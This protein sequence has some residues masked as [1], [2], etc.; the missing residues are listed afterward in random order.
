MLKLYLYIQFQAI[1]FTKGLVMSA[2]FSPILP[3]DLGFKQK[4]KLSQ[5]QAILMSYLA[6]LPNWA[7]DVNN[8]GYF[9]IL[10]AKIMEDLKM[11]IK[12][13]ENNL[14]VL[15]DLDLIKRARTKVAEWS[16]EKNFRTVKITIKGKEYGLA[17]SK[18]KNPN[19]IKEWEVKYEN[20]EKLNKK[21]VAEN[22]TLKSQSKK[23]D[24][25]DSLESFQKRVTKEFGKSCKPI[26]NFVEN[27]DNWAKDSQ[28]WIN[29]YGKLTI[30]TPNGDF[31]QI[32]NPEKIANFWQWLF[33]N[34]ERCGVIKTEQ[35]EKKDEVSIIPTIYH[36]LPFIGLMILVEGEKLLINKLE[37]VLG[38]VKIVLQNAKTWQ[39]SNPQIVDV[40]V[41]TNWIVKRREELQR[42]DLQTEM[43]KLRDLI[44]EII[45]FQNQKW[46]ISSFIALKEGK[47]QI[48]VKK[49]TILGKKPPQTLIDN[50]RKNDPIIAFT[51]NKARE[52]IDYNKIK[53]KN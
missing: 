37:A 35:T 22:K 34:P 31:K 12:T 23:T 50:Q 42:F 40:E 4:Y 27:A 10:T 32:I 1:I 43:T 51:P 38:G 44:G 45:L 25:T 36:L 14:K 24:T 2:I 8:D 53:N 15:E 21:L 48:M 39:L 16:N 28:F 18:C 19:L 9:L 52:F 49:I 13:V 47:I 6:L 46:E 33:K 11:G 26:C 5:S 29:S 3:L 17:Y 30:K 41:L 20:L 7:K